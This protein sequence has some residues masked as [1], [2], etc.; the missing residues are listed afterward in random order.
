MRTKATRCVEVWQTSNLRLLRLDEGKKEESKTNY[1]MKIYMVCPIPY[2]DHNYIRQMYEFLHCR[3]YH[4]IFC[5]SQPG[6]EPAA[7]YK[8][9]RHESHSAAQ[10][11]NSLVS[12]YR[13]THHVGHK[14]PICAVESPT[15]SKKLALQ[16]AYVVYAR[17][18]AIKYSVKTCMIS[19]IFL[20]IT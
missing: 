14:T 1:S 3:A 8:A 6:F 20:M 17:L 10:P 9:V 18:L 13:F 4:L 2:G 15:V 7:S 12:C 11:R 16:I 19:F 5:V